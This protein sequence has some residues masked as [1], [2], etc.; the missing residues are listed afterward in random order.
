MSAILG[1]M[2]LQMWSAEI[3]V[4]LGG[5]VFAVATMAFLIWASSKGYLPRP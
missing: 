1:V 3:S 4:S 2:A 5:I